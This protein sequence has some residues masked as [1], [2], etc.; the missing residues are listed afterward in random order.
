MTSARPAAHPHAIRR[1]ML[2]FFCV[3]RY[4]NAQQLQQRRFL[5][6]FYNKRPFYD[7]LTVL[8]TFLVRAV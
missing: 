2:R 4:A 6:R 1:R 3:L 8:L 5:V 7:P